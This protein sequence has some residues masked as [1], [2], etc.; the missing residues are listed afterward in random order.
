MWS[1]TTAPE[2]FWDVQE[3]LPEHRPRP[4]PSLTHPP[5]LSSIICTYI[6]TLSLAHY[7]CQVYLSKS[8]QL[9]FVATFKCC[10]YSWSK[11]WLKYSICHIVDSAC[12]LKM[13]HHNLRVYRNRVWWRRGSTLRQRRSAKMAYRQ[14][15]VTYTRTHTHTNSHTHA[16][17][18]L[19]QDYLCFRETSGFEEVESSKLQNSHSQH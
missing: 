14:E 11:V 5:P 19:L 3:P 9:H 16:H 6:H 18:P 13:Y 8:L 1:I 12:L 10:I 7:R 4:H 15:I 2:P 17:T